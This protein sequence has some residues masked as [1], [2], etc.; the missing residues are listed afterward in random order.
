MIERGAPRSRSKRVNYVL[1]Q[2]IGFMLRF[3]HQR[4]TGIFAREIGADITT[5][6][7]AALS[8]LAE[9][10]ACSQ[11]QLGRLTAMDVATIKGVVD[12]LTARGLTNTRRDPNDQRR[13]LVELTAS[14]QQLVI[15]ISVKAASASRKT[16]APLNSEERLLLIALLKRL[17]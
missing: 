15:K 10:G 6:Q 16:L 7:W 17:R 4:H 3:S 9:K 1:D 8:K 11:N 13:L 5:G 2:Q 12:R 14:G